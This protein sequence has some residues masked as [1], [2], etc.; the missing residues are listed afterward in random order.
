MMV[1]DGPT[2]FWKSPSE[3][4]ITAW[5]WF[6]FAKYPMLTEVAELLVGGDDGRE[7]GGITGRALVVVVEVL[8]DVVVEVVEEVEVL[9][10]VV[11]VVEVD[12]DELDVLMDVVEVEV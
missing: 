5:A 8:V 4:P 9:V 6:R 11:E 1:V 10:D 12:V 7:I 3:R 2:N